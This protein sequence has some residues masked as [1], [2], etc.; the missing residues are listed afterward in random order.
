MIKNKLSAYSSHPDNQLSTHTANIKSNC[1]QL[2]RLKLQFD[3]NVNI[4][5]PTYLHF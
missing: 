4:G 3:L 2:L 5:I 1:I